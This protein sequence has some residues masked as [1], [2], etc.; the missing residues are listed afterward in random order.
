MKYKVNIEKEVFMMM[1]YI[2]EADDEDDAID[3]ISMGLVEPKSSEVLSEE[4]RDDDY[5]IEEIEDDDEDEN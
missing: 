5:D 3:K 4:F 2:V 1:K